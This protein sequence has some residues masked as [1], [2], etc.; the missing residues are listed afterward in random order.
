MFDCTVCIWCRGG[1]ICSYTASL[2]TGRGKAALIEEFCRIRSGAA[3]ACGTAVIGCA[4][5]QSHRCD[6]HSSA[7][8]DGFYQS[9]VV[10]LDLPQREREKRI[11]ISWTETWF[12]YQV[13]IVVLLNGWLRQYL[14]ILT[15]LAIILWKTHTKTFIWNCLRDDEIDSLQTHHFLKVDQS[16][17]KCLVPLMCE[18]HIWKHK[19]WDI[20]HSASFLGHTETIKFFIFLILL[21]YLWLL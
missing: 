21:E 9:P 7:H 13:H 10:L 3:P 8:P 12:W 15:V 5:C 6:A 20:R 4:G 16:V 14:M 17:S 1:R 11:R 2:F 19:N 18:S